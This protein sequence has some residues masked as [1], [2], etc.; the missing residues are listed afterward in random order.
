MELT[1]LPQSS[2]PRVPPDRVVTD[3]GSGSPMDIEDR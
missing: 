3:S 1:S 2:I